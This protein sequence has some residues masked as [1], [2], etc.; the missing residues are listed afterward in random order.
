[1]TL[2]GPASSFTAKAKVKIAETKIFIDKQSRAWVLPR[3]S[4]NTKLVNLRCSASFCSEKRWKESAWAPSPPTVEEGGAAS[5]IWRESTLLRRFAQRGPSGS[6]GGFNANLGVFEKFAFWRVVFSI[7]HTLC[8][9]LVN[10][11]TFSFL[12]VHSPSSER[13]ISCVPFGLR[14][15]FCGEK[16]MFVTNT[17]YSRH[18]HLELNLREIGTRNGPHLN[19]RRRNRWNLESSE[20]RECLESLCPFRTTFVATLESKIWILRKL[21]A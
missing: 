6:F 9:T 21:N 2:R 18:M 15:F 1:M 8:K 7:D 19:H 14:K 3:H 4:K 13:Q 5:N 10:F 16:I 12:K 11:F 20:K 17:L